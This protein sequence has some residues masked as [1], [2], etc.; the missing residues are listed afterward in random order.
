M[1]LEDLSPNPQNPR[2]ITDDKLKMLKKAIEQFGDIS[3]FVYNQT[4]KRLVSGHQRKK[5]IPKDSQITIVNQYSQ[6]T[7][8]GTIADGFIVS[9]GE[10]F[11]YREVLWDETTEKA[12]NIAANQHGGEF[13]LIGLASWVN[14]LDAHNIDLDLLGFDSKELDELMAPINK[15]GS[16][17]EDEVP[18]QVEAKT[19]LGDLYRLGNHRLLCG[20]STDSTNVATLVG[21]ERM[22][23]VFTDPPYGMNL[24]TDY[25]D[26]GFRKAKPY[27][28]VLG[29]DQEFDFLT[30]YALTES[31]PEQF[32]FGADY[33]CDK[34]PKGGSWIVWDKKTTEGLQRMY[35]SDFELCWSKQKHDR[36]IAR[37]AWAGPFGH[38]KTDDGPTKVHPTMK[39]IKLI[40]WFFE[41]YKGQNVI[42]LF[43]GSGS[44]LIACEKTNR[45]CFM[46]ELDP[47]YCDVIMARWEKY[48]SQK[49]EWINEKNNGS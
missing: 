2:R 46:M 6:P 43:G 49:A 8:S 37:V 1:K 40:C 27:K 44:T 5:V 3:G 11:A 24:D 38:N 31:V 21:S 47:H 7:K 15:E 28:K 48:T 23:M 34:L 32:W 14:D 13:D 22:D 29:D 10:K 41:R 9:N 36:E 39:A 42:D 33:Y 17:N 18:E 35:G 12:A 4:T 25:K 20:D 16:C 26:N 45:K 30:V 19:K